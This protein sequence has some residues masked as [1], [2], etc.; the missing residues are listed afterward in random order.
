MLAGAKRER[1]K[2]KGGFDAFVKKIILTE[3]PTT[4]SKK[5][6]SSKKSAD[7]D[8]QREAEQGKSAVSMSD[9]GLMQLLQGTSAQP[10]H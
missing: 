4:T 1:Q 8:S 6:K 5:E 7:M 10:V 9:A 2:G 3:K